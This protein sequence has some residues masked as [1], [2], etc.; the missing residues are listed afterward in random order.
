MI[1]GY[2]M[3]WTLVH[4]ASV[5]IGRRGALVA[6][7]FLVA[8]CVAYVAGRIIVEVGWGNSWAGPMSAVAFAVAMMVLDRSG[9]GG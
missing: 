5:L 8:I 7:G 1:V 2:A 4:S 9:G 3:T 6:F